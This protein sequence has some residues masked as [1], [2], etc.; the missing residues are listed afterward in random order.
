LFHNLILVEIVLKLILLKVKFCKTTIYFIKLL[1]SF[2]SSKFF[3]FQFGTRSLLVGY[4]GKVLFGKSQIRGVLVFLKCLMELNTSNSLCKSGRSF[5]DIEL[6]LR[7]IK[8]VGIF[9][10]NDCVVMCCVGTKLIQRICTKLVR[11]IVK[12]NQTIC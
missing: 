2:K 5:I 10:Q 4:L 9:I 12:F 7:L 11:N 6:I 1:N 3:E 8:I